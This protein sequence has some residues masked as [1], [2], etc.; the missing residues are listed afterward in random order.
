MQVYEIRFKVFL[1]QMLKQEESLSAVASFIDGVLVQESTWEQIHRENRFKFYCHNAP[2]PIEED[3]I[4]KKEQVY[5][6]IIRSVNKELVEYL[7]EK[8]PKYDD[9]LMKGLICDLRILPKRHITELY[10]I[11]PV[12]VKG[13]DK[14]YWR[15]SM[16]FEGF[17]ERLKINLIK[18]YNEL[19]QMKLEEDFML[20]TRL[21]LK[22]K[23]PIAVPY[24]E[25]KLLADKVQIQVAENPTAQKLAY[26]ALGT[27]L[28]EM[29]SRG[30]GFVNCHFL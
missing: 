16:T 18:K 17:E 13:S 6:I 4:Y 22:N 11:T 3:G 10:S 25:I 29:N 20:H 27:G 2:Y 7:A 1:L 30:M 19:E 24:K 9:D 21:E 15:D 12:I 5:Q 14:G 23:Q 26:M 8:L 28:C